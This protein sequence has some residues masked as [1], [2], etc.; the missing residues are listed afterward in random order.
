VS[1]RLEL[2]LTDEQFEQLA[3]RVSEL[4]AAGQP[5][6][7]DGW[8]RGAAAIAEYIDAPASRIYSLAAANRIPVERDGSNLI[9]R[10][11]ELDAWL[12]AGGGKR[13]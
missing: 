8:L 7:A 12:R 2:Q 10:K 11:S 1:L 4:L 5:P 13:P 9:A 3:Q 6:A